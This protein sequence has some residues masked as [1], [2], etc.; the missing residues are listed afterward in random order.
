MPQNTQVNSATLIIGPTGA[1]KSALARTLADYLHTKY[2]K[3]LY[4][5][6]CDGG[7]FPA[8]VQEGIAIGII[9]GFRMRTR[10]TGDLGLAFETCQ[11]SVQGWWP[12]RINPATCEVEPG[13]EMVA[14]VVKRLA[15]YCPEGHLVKTVLLQSQLGP[16]SCPTCKAMVTTQNMTV[17]ESLVQSRGFED[18]GGVFFDGLTSMLSWGAM[19]LGQRAGRMELKGEEGAI[20]GKVISGN[21][22]LGGVTRAHIGFQQT[23]GEE[24]AHLALGIPN[25]LVPPIFTALTME[26][27]DEG[28]LT[29]IGPKISGRAKTDEAGQWFGNC[30]EAAKV[31]AEMG[32]GEQR[33]LYLSEFTDGDG[34]RHLLKHRGS[35]NTMPDRLADPPNDTAPFTQF[36]LG[37]FFQ[38]LDDAL[39][40]G[41]EQAKKIYP[42]APGLAEGIQEY[43]DGGQATT[44]PAAAVQAAPSL[45]APSSSAR[46]APS[47]APRAPSAPAAA[48][49]PAVASTPASEAGPAK[50]ALPSSAAISVPVAPVEAPASIAP[51]IPAPRAGVAPPPGGRPMKP[52]AAAPRVPVA[53]PRAS[54]PPPA[55]R[56]A[57]KA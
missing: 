23:R 51:A 41:I 10:D 33:V 32:S 39:T 42:D 27:L 30:L 1:G 18:R 16:Q 8:P 15:M 28:N 7:G 9:K 44:A 50:E 35:P 31:P 34:R 22:R 12:R 29:V 48:A 6:N 24:Y 40:S 54:T 52:A 25:L 2:K 19:E 36:N 47:R 56:P 26:T 46:R 4:Y 13:V 49:Q 3:V 5:Y 57:T 17:R 53:A 45:Q 11:R 38:K 14:P 55:A 21:I 20:G 43:G 37:V